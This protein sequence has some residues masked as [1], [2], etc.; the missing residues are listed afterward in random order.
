MIINTLVFIFGIILLVSTLMTLSVWLRYRHFLIKTLLLFWVSGIFGYFAQGYFNQTNVMGLLAFGF[1][2]ITVIFLLKIYHQAIGIKKSLTGEMFFL[3]SSLL[4]GCVIV[5]VS[6]SY[7]LGSLVFCVSCCVSLL[8]GGLRS[9]E[10][11]SNQS[12][13]FIQRYRWLLIFAGLHFLDY[14]YFRTNLSLSIIGF[15]ISILFYFC[16]AIFVP[17]LIL[18][19]MSSD[20][21]RQ[22][23]SEVVLRTN[24]LNESYIQLQDAF[25][26]LKKNKAQ[27]NVLLSDNRIRMSALVHDIATPL[28]IVIHYFNAITVD[29]SKS[30][31]IIEKKAA[32]IQS[33]FR[34]IKQI[35]EEARQTHSEVLGKSELT[36]KQVHIRSLIEETLK[37]FEFKV[38]EKNICLNVEMD[39]SENLYVMANDN[40][41][42]NQV[43]SNLLS[44]A[45][46]FTNTG[47]S[48]QIKAISLDYNRVG[49]II[50]DNGIGIPKE[51]RDAIFTF[52]QVTTTV[53]TLGE[54]GTGL[55]LPI[56][57]QYTELMGGKISLLPNEKEIGTK[58]QIELQRAA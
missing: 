11:S 18:Q 6:N 23:E 10:G 19:K 24:Q 17:V 8:N 50:E 37:N 35:L 40:W 54:S 56:V 34:S 4:I 32:T 1:N 16:F 55:G 53:G 47:G 13:F 9:P 36:L 46:K 51:K 43:L 57:K 26:S 27:I 30:L 44:N 2:A 31:E 48:I 45:I 14:P 12:D 38:A 3:A 20:Y 49:I 39:D 41:L 15:S 29:K 33:A 21:T 25:E 28:Q 58:F 52:D 5:S 22:L 7:A 42:K